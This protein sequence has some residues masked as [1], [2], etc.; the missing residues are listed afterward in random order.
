VFVA[1]GRIS[2][3][4]QHPIVGAHYI[5]ASETAFLQRVVGGG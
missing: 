1:A 3:A 2:A 4:A 5:L